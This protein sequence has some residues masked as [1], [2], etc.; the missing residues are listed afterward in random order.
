MSINLNFN[1]TSSSAQSQES[2][3]LDYVLIAGP[4]RSG[5]TWLGHILNTYQHC[6]Y[7]HEPFLPSKS[8]PYN[9]WRNDLNSGDIEELRSRFQSLCR[10]CYFEID[11][12]P[13][14][15]SFRR[16]A[17]SFRR[18][19][20]QLLRLLYGLGKRIDPI[21]NLYEWYGR[22]NLS[23]QTPVLIKEVNFP[24]ELLPR[25]C[26]VLQPH[27]IAIIRNPFANIASYFKGV[28]LSLFGQARPRK[29]ASLR[30][31][32]D[33]PSGQHLWKYREQLEQ[34]SLAQL[35][36]V[37]WRVQVEPLVE[38]AR[39]YEPSLVVLYEDLCADPHGKTAEIFEFLG[40]E[41]TPVTSNF[42]NQSISGERSLP[43]TSKAYY[44]VYR[45][46]QESLS[47]WKTQLTAE[48]K[49]DIAS[50][51]RESP[52]QDFWSDIPL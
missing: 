16:P 6:S 18:Q 12:P 9:Q 1:Q 3:R 48:Q 26:E 13:P 2:S 51:I 35:E 50:V 4:G 24:N 32:I 39:T 45:D 38:Y 20:P 25:L 17:K 11:Q 14:G 15:K 27:L 41:L 47:K 21:K 43:K 22:A 33:S 36:A 49:A 31:D 28:E 46:P 19:N 8:T 40:W 37:R 5:T 7:K 42:I 52:L 34:M 23:E 10:D 44:S 29:I 30:K